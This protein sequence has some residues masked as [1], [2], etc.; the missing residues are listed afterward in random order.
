MATTELE[1]HTDSVVSLAFNATGEQRE[2][3]RQAAGRGTSAAIRQRSSSRI[4]G[5]SQHVP[6]GSWYRM[7]F[8]VGVSMFPLLQAVTVSSCAAFLWSLQCEAVVE[9]LL[10][11]APPPAPGSSSSHQPE[12]LQLLQPLCHSLVFLPCR[13][14]AC[15]SQPGLYSA[16]VVCVRRQLCPDA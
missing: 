2:L 5:R 11:D 9:A 1:G 8:N 13:Q 3:G 10:G 15:Y 7:G 4:F 16:C 6:A 14:L 12:Q